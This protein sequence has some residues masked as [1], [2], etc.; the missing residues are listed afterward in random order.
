MK[1][2]LLVLLFVPFTCFAQ[3]INKESNGWTKVVNIE[4][5][6]DDIYTK[7]NEWVAETYKNPDEVSKLNSKS[8]VIVGG[9]LSVNFLTQG[10]SIP[11]WLEHTV[12]ISIRDNKFKIDVTVGNMMAQQFSTIKTPASQVGFGYTKLS[13]EGYM[14]MSKESLK[15]IYSGKKLEK[16]YQKFVVDKIDTSY[17][18]Y[19]SSYQNMV[20]KISSLYKSIEDK[21]NSSD[22]W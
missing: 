2:L 19:E 4:M 14:E 6:A 8:K 5:S 18:E 13:K 20:D 1:K 10:Q 16:N 12:S 11:Y 17:P 22:D 9:N 15:S 7:V 21:V 3:E